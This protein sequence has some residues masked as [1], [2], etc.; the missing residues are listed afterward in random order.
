MTL[1][2]GERV[3]LRPLTRG[4]R[5]GLLDLFARAPSRDLEYFRS[6]A[7]DAGVVESWV[8][9][10]DLR[11]VFP[12]IAVANGKIVGDATLHFGEHYA[13]HRGWVRIYLD[14]DYR[15]RGIGTFMLQNL[16]KVARLAGL[17]QLYAEVL[18]LQHPVVSAFEALGF[19]HEVTMSDSFITDGGETLDTAILVLRL[20]GHPA[21]L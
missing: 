2:G 13:R 8:D 21:G 19:Q 7:G 18:T 17:Q 9:N 1:N 16:I 6:D 11:K 14:H 5:H 15:R 4:D 10:L 12:L 20:N 3:I